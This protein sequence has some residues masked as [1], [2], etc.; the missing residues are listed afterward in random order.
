MSGAAL[1]PVNPHRVEF[2]YPG[3]C[4]YVV[5]GVEA[6]PQH[7]NSSHHCQ[8][9]SLLTASGLWPLFFSFLLKGLCAAFV[10]QSMVPTLLIGNLK[11]R[12]QHCAAVV[13]TQPSCKP[14]QMQQLAAGMAMSECPV[15]PPYAMGDLFWHYRCQAE[16]PHYACLFCR[17]CLCSWPGKKMSDAHQL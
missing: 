13:R 3:C 1:I 2:K 17:H 7:T 4:M 11:Q 10:F 12:D 8:H 16:V 14:L 9:T 5:S 6:S 15:I